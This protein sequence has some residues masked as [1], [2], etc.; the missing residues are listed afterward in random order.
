[1]AARRLST[2]ATKERQVSNRRK[3]S[4]DVSRSG[5]RV[6][7]WRE[8]S[9]LSDLLVCLGLVAVTWAVFGQTI[10]YHFVNFDDDL[11]VYNAPAIQSGLTLKGIAAAFVGQ[12]AHNWH[13]LTTISHMLDCQ[14]YSLNAG[15]HHATN[16]ILHTIA[17]LLLFWVLQQMTGAPWKSALVAALFAVHPLHV[18]SV[19]WVSERKDILSAVFFFLMLNAYNRYAR[20][21]SVMRYLAVAVFFAAGLM[22]KSMLVS[23]PIILLLL[24]YWPLR[25]FEQPSLIIEKTK[26]SECDDQRC[27]I[28]RLYLEKIPLFVLSAV[29]CIVTFVLQKR[30]AGAIPPLPFLWRVQNAFVSYVIYV[31][32]TLWPARLAVFYP[33][34]ND[35]LALWEVIFA[36]LLLLAITT[37]AIVFRKQRPYLLTGWFWYLVML[38][39]VI[40]IV[41][42]GEQGHADRYTYLPHIGLFVAMVWFAINVVTFRRP[43]PQ[44][45][46]TIAVAVLIIL[47][48]AWTAFIQTS[49]W[50]DSEALWTHALAV[51]SDNDIAHNNLGY[52]CADRGE[53]D[54]AISHFESAARIRSGKRDPHY[55]LASAFVQMNVADALAKKGRS[56]DAMVHYEEAIRLQPNYAD[57]YY[58]RGSLLF[59]K[60]RIDEA[61]ADWETVLE[62]HPNDADAHTS[63]GNALLQKGSLREAIA[64]YV[65]ALGLAPE[66]PH[67]RN[68]VAWILA[69]A[70]DSSIRDGARALGFAQEAVQLSGG[71]EPQFLRTLA[72]AYAES[73]RFSEAIAVSQQ[74]A[75]TATM[76]GKPDMAK[77]LE[78]DLV[79]Y[80]GNLPVR[81]NPPGN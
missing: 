53:L 59:A 72:A 21:P 77:R 45:A 30:T 36:I 58:N 22:S 46:L 66:D 44:V 1:M 23:V 20:E 73:G 61:I 41:Q 78:K 62:M 48:L 74:A 60:G 76:Q 52:L 63:L 6:R 18:E 38:I 10:R 14:L 35:T 27:I 40:G 56:D 34:P 42:V 79:L 43:K 69:T 9:R 67:S 68:N 2:R 7:G 50:R 55:D 64:H 16:V 65:T 24:D 8:K 25:R 54:K 4:S 12:H 80:R 57:A 29:V 81:E 17:V 70:S 47:A 11:Y 51:T 3:H 15:G 32:K 39:P 13:P 33:H 26:I 28:R 71:R 75:V 49:Y 5:S 31:W 19:A 37:T